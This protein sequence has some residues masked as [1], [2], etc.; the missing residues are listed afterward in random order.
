L[1]TFDNLAFLLR[2]VEDLESFPERLRPD[3][4][5]RKTE[6]MIPADELRRREEKRL[7]PALEAWNEAKKIL[8][9]AIA[10][11]E[12][13]EKDYRELSHEVQRR[14]DALQLV[15]NMSMEL[16]HATP[17]GSQGIGEPAQPLP[18][19]AENT[20]VAAASAA[21]DQSTGRTSQKQN[22]IMS[23]SSRRLFPANWRAKHPQL[24]ILN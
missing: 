23:I 7:L 16:E 3:D 10:L 19:L 14:L 17:A 13:R 5:S 24:S 15:I 11:A 9:Q 6:S 18:V 2:I 12:A 21:T 1:I 20:A 22:G 4:V 8:E